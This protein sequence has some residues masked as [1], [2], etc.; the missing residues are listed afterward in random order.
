M[1]NRIESTKKIQELYSK[2]V[3]CE[4][5]ELCK[6][7][8]NVVFWKAETTAKLMLIGEAPG[9]SED[10]QGVPFVGRS[11]KLL[12][13]LVA[14]AGILESDIFI[15]NIAKCRPPKNRNPKRSEIESCMYWLLKELEILKPQLVV[16]VGRVSAQTLIDK[17]FLLSADHGKLFKKSGINYTAIYHPA[18]LLR[19]PSLIE[20]VREDFAYIHNLI[21]K[22]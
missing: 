14:E 22:A 12:R 13:K 7:R 1:L 9:A 17:N 8:K 16:C 4:N 6:A 20:C 15:S 10:E 21:Y 3:D 5:C 2:L 19:T 18:A 11:G